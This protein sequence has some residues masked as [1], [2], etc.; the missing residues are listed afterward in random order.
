MYIDRRDYNAV[1]L[2]APAPG[3]RGLP[4][5]AAG[6]PAYSGRLRRLLSVSN[7][8]TTLGYR[9]GWQASPFEGAPRLNHL[10]RPPQSTHAKIT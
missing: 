2:A 3:R 6:R 7:P 4:N 1:R 5:L 9:S 10:P 8:K